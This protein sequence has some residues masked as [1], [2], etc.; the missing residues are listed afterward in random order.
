MEKKYSLFTFY[1]NQKQPNSG[2]LTKTPDVS[3]CGL[4]IHFEPK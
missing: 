4:H 1:I 2:L 3:A